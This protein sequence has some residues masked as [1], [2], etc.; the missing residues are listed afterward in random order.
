MEVKPFVSWEVLETIWRLSKDP[1]FQTLPLSKKGF[2]GVQQRLLESLECPKTEEIK[3]RY[4]D[5]G[6]EE[7]D[8]VGKL[9]HSWIKLKAIIRISSWL[10][11]QFGNP[12]FSKAVHDRAKASRQEGVIEDLIDGDLYKSLESSHGT[13]CES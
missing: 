8:T 2:K 3:I 5:N 7:E 11:Y 9:S 13:C 1:L 6:V 12:K 10:R 4:F